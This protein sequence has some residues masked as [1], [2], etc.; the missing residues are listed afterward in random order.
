MNRP[1]LLYV[2]DPTR[3]CQGLW[4]A[5][6]ALPGARFLEPEQQRW[7]RQHLGRQLRAA[8]SAVGL[9]PKRGQLGRYPDGAERSSGGSGA[10]HTHTACNGPPCTLADLC[11]EVETEQLRQRGDER[12]QLAVIEAQLLLHAIASR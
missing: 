12:P 1:L 4:P 6:R 10:A 8:E 11:I 5:A 7:P 2:S 9:G 3:G